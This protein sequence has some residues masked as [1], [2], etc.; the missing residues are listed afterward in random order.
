VATKDAPKLTQLVVLPTPPFWLVTAII[1]A[2]C[3]S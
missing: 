1:F 2:T 3:L